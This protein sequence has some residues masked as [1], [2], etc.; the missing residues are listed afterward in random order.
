MN[1]AIEQTTL[2]PSKFVSVIIALFMLF[3]SGAY[4]RQ[5]AET[6]I[7][8]LGIEGGW[9][10]YQRGSQEGRPGVFLDVVKGIERHSDLTFKPVYFPAKRAEKA[11]N[12]GLVDFDFIC[13]EWMK[14]GNPGASRK[15]S[16]PL[17]YINE[18]IVTLAN[19]THLFPTKQS[20]HGKVVGTIAGYFYHDDDKFFR[21]DFLS[22]SKLIKGLARERFKGAILEFGTANHWAR[23][24]KVDIG[25]AVQHSQ[26]KLRFRLREEKWHLLDDI[27]HA[28]VRLHETGELKAI[29]A[30]HG[31]ESSFIDAPPVSDR[32]LSD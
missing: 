14:D 18:Y 12:D 32:Q 30:S 11:M 16:L 2:N 20:Y 27:N 4:A 7:F 23:E 15:T 1:Q 5:S 6:L 10:P 29:L 31:L 22:E 3:C 25:F 17:F 9:I 24:H 19:N 26:G 28:I 21:M 8:D 13:L